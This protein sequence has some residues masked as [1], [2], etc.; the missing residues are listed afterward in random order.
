VELVEK[1]RQPILVTI[2]ALTLSKTGLGL[3]ESLAPQAP[4]LLLP[5]VHDTDREEAATAAPLCD[6]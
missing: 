2:G 5:E 3:L 6:G 1:P 4:E